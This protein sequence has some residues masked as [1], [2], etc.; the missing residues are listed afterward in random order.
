MNDTKWVVVYD[1]GRGSFCKY[2]LQVWMR[3]E[4]GK[5]SLEI[6]DFDSKEEAEA[7]IADAKLDAAKV[8]DWKKRIDSAYRRAEAARQRAAF[9]L[10]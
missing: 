8:I 9:A 6:F 1:S 4:S 3:R 2:R 10:S 7:F 5:K